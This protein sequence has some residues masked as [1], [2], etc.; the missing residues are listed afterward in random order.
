MNKIL[1]IIPM[2]GKAEYTDK[3]V[4]LTF[5]HA[6]VP[7]D[8]LVVDDGSPGIYLNNDVEVLRLPKNTGYTN[9]TNQGILWAQE[10][11]YDYVLLLNNDTEP[12]EQFVK[13]LLDCL[14]SDETVGIAS[15]ARFCPKEGGSYYVEL[16]GMDLLRGIQAVTDPEHLK[17][18]MIQCNWVPVSC[19]LVR[20]SVIREVGLLDKKM[21]THSSDLEFCLRVKIAGYKIII[22]TM[23]QA[24]HFHEVTTKEHGITPERDQKVLLEHLSGMYYA[25]FMKVMPLDHDSKTWGKLEFIYF[26]KA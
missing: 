5:K 22:V 9:A 19:A 25:Q 1:V 6:G 13:L 12:R 3:C 21:R 11:N 10:R 18:E 24:V 20:M 8:I 7:V 17:D 26:K 4:E 23:S 15:S 16:Y 14:T 2:F